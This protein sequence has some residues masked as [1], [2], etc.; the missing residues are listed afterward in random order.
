MSTSRNAGDVSA[1]RADPREVVLADGRIA[2]ADATREPDLFW[3]LKGGG[4]HFGVVTE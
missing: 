3:A 1:R 4:G 2:V